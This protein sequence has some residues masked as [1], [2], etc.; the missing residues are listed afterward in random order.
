MRRD[1][2][3]PTNEALFAASASDRMIDPPRPRS[4]KDDAG[5]K[6]AAAI[7]ALLVHAIVLTPLVV[8]IDF[9]KP[10]APPPEA[11]PVEV[12]IE[13]PPDQAQPPP[14]PVDLTPAT[15]APRAR[16]KDQPE[17]DAPDETST[18]PQPTPKTP[19]AQPSAAPAAEASPAA[20]P[21]QPVTTTVAEEEAA[22]PTPTPTETPAAPALDP[23]AL[24]RALTLPDF[25]AG[26]TFD[27]AGLSPYESIMVGKEK[28]TYLTAVYGRVM[29]NM[30][31]PPREGHGPRP[32]EGVIN[33][34]VDGKGRLLR[35]EFVQHS[36]DPALDEAA[37][38][39]IAAGAPYPA[40][41]DHV[42]VGLKFVYRAE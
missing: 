21:P 11:I 18:A 9:S 15:D 24:P 16:A 19:E 25:N 34:T 8:S 17:R 13:P 39:A 20:Q 35:R 41:P 38:E 30:P 14:R 42:T 3:M 28:A 2:P 32:A 33:F 29:A 6:A 31:R 26:P 4:F 27:V 1:G 37:F 10:E 12:V 22:P 5:L 36:G 40:P 23:N 7:G